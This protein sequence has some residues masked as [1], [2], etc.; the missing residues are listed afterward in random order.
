MN[1]RDATPHEVQMENKLKSLLLNFCYK[2]YLQKKSDAEV[3]AAIAAKDLPRMT[4]QDW[5]NLK[6]WFRMREMSVP[7]KM[8]LI[9]KKIGIGV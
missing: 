2:L 7:A 3:L 9:R 8:A 5:W 4:R 1:S 6:Q